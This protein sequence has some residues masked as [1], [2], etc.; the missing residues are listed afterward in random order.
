ML[1]IDEILHI[2]RIVDL[3]LELVEARELDLLKHV[4]LGADLDGGITDTLVAVEISPV[5]VTTATSTLASLLLASTAESSAVSTQ[6]LESTTLL[7]SLLTETATATTLTGGRLEASGL[8][9]STGSVVDN[10]ER[11]LIL[12]VLVVEGV[13]SVASEGDIVV[14][15]GMR[16]EGSI[17]LLEAN[18]SVLLV[19]K[20]LLFEGYVGLCLE[21]R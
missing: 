13:G 8:L 6:A 11:S 18:K 4:P 16:F 10:G 19:E 2:L 12:G 20:C 17:K 21:M 3:K 5:V 9:L 7:T 14:C 1:P 15:E